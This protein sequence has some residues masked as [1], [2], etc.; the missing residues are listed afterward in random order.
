MLN[1][2]PNTHKSYEVELVCLVTLVTFEFEGHS[3]G[4]GNLDHIFI[5][6]IYGV[7]VYDEKKIVLYYFSWA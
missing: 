7:I 3:I 4:Q 5:F 2:P 6:M 1:F